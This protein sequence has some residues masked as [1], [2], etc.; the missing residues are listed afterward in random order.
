MRAAD[1]AAK[2]EP[3]LRARRD[4]QR[5][6][7]LEDAELAV[8]LDAVAAEPHH[9]RR[10]VELRHEPGRVVRRAA[11]QLAFLDEHDVLHSRLREVVRA[12]DPGDARRRSRRAHCAHPLALRVVER[13]R[14]DLGVDPVAED[15]DRERVPGSAYA[16]GTYASAMLAPTA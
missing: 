13:L 3:A 11:R 9:R 16:S 8:Q 12:A 7:S 6:D 4:A 5:A 2:L 10:R 15:V 14:A 1:A